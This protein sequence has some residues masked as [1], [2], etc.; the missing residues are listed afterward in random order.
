[1]DTPTL[2]NEGLP[3]AIPG[4]EEVKVESVKEESQTCGRE[5]QDPPRLVQGR[6]AYVFLRVFTIQVV[7]PTVEK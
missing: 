4:L 6:P 3:H 2:L 7:L 1:M 5:F